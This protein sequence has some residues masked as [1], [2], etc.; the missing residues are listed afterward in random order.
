MVSRRSISSRDV[1]AARLAAALSVLLTALGL[2]FALGGLGTGNALAAEGEACPNE[3]LRQESNLNQSTGR[4]YSTELPDC[5]AY[6]QVTPAE[7]GQANINGEYEGGLGVKPFQEAAADGE[8][9]MY[10]AGDALPGDTS[11]QFYG[12]ESAFRSAGGW[13]TTSLSAPHGGDADFT[14]FSP[15]LSCAG[16]ETVEPMEALSSGAPAPLPAGETTEEVQNLYVWNRATGAYTLISNANPTNRLYIN[17]LSTNYDFYQIYGMTEDCSR[18]VFA[19]EYRLLANAPSSGPGL[20]EWDN[21]ELRLVSQLPDETVSP[22]KGF[23]PSEEYPLVG[24]FSH[25][26][27][28]VFFTGTSD[29][30]TDAGSEEVFM[31]EGTST[32][33]VSQS[34]TATRDLGAAF[35][36][37][38]SEGTQVLFLA[39]YG[40]TSNSSGSGTDL[41]DYNTETRA[42]T[43]ISADSNPSDL[44]GAQVKGVLG[45]SQDASYVYF[46]ALGQLPASNSAGSN[47][48]AENNRHGESNIYVWHDGRLGYVATMSPENNLLRRGIVLSSRVTPDGRYLLLSSPKK[49][50]MYNNINAEGRPVEELYLYSAQTESL[51]CISCNP[52]GARPLGGSETSIEGFNNGYAPRNLSDDGD[53]VFFTSSDS[54]A[55]GA[56]AGRN[57]YEWEREGV[58]S[59]TESE[60]RA[61]A[62]YSGGCIYLLA[63]GGSLLDASANG[64]GVFV[65]SHLSFVAQDTDGSEDVYEV[66][67]DGGFPAPKVSSCVG[68]ECQG[69]LNAP[70]S[71]SVPGSTGAPLVGNAAPPGETRN[72]AKPAPRSISTRAQKLAQ[73]L[74]QC[75]KKAR[76][77]RTACDRQARKKYGAKAKSK[78]KTK[79]ANKKSSGKGSK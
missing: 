65:A 53:Q 51:T 13:L 4:P 55:A 74:R 73:A 46:S 37:A 43:D 24:A 23:M 10:G 72:P 19:T 64:D 50:T 76:K 2:A 69:E 40:L 79:S 11:G 78:S 31:R 41:Y 14:T 3:Q 56:T 15:N 21:G 17:P 44:G 57:A 18:V 29:G 26:G 33:E 54:L 8:G 45:L 28:R 49:L 70:L 34:Q 71:F 58:G 77:K 7:K 5:R 1:R 47:S 27:T 48:E 67:V 60:A 61:P 6:E 20:Y 66:R 62:E 75:K 30:P 38:S 35:Q 59:C 12:Q 36:A 68:E 42:L 39:N 16:D 32:M 52:G 63:A 22:V 25:D 9:I